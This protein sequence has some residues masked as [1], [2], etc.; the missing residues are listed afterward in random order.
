MDKVSGSPEPTPNL[1]WRVDLM[2]MIRTTGLLTG[3]MTLALTGFAGAAENDNASIDA[4]RAELSELRAQNNSLSARVDAQDTEWLNEERASEI[5]GIVQDVLADSQSRTSL[6]DSGMMAGYKAGKGFFL[7]NADG[8]FSLNVSGQLQTRWVFNNN[9]DPVS[10]FDGTTG[11]AIVDNN[12]K[13]NWGFQVRR[14]HVQF[15]GNVIDPTW[16]YAINGAFEGPD[17]GFGN[18]TNGG[19][20]EFQEAY[21]AK[22][23]DNGIT[24]TL[25]QFK[26][27][28]LREE[29]VESS[30][31]LAVERS[32]VNEIFNQDRAVG[33]MASWNNDDWNL[34]G[35]Y[36]NGQRTAVNQQNRY[37]N[38]SDNNTNWSF[39]ARGEW[40]LSGD[41]SDFD[42]FTSSQ[43]DDQ[44]M[45]IGVAAMGQ[46]YN[47]NSA[48]YNFGPNL[49][50]AIASALLPAG[51]QVPNLDGTTVFGLTADFSAKFS[52]F[53]LFASG[54]WQNYDT[55]AANSNSFNSWGVVVQGGYSLNDQ[56]E[57][58]ARYEEAN[59]NVEETLGTGALATAASQYITEGGN[60]SILTLGAN[61]FI[62]ENVKFTV[63]WGINFAKNLDLYSSPASDTGWESSTGSSQWLIR[64]QLQLLF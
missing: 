39:S 31:Q 16:T 44:A 32:V 55:G 42:S 26:T 62:S 3:A 6:Q 28:W 58:F 15:Q 64:A 2:T 59:A 47:E 35:S 49:N 43:G 63:D 48:A 57:I 19:T 29:L 13:Q 52:G 50:D 22:E 25:G 45:M 37:S 61:Y 53:S 60:A 9:P 17:N 30:Q 33:I 23:L 41:W 54:V 14:A 38:F 4:L 20:F 10:G 24:I 34:A 46:R 1:F 51:L 27:P 40:K 56:W 18:P 21:I 12:E 36:N 8:S 5:R 7:S 11:Q